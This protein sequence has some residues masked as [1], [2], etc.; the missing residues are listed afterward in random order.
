[1]KILPLRPSA[2]FKQIG[3]V[4]CFF[5]PPDRGTSTHGPAD[6]QGLEDLIELLLLRG[7][8]ILPEGV[9]RLALRFAFGPPDLV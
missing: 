2:L 5:T 7:L 4:G 9:T 1:M 6:T 3:K 8:L